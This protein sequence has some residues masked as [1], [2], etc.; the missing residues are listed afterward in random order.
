MKLPLAVIIQVERKN[1]DLIKSPS[2]AGGIWKFG[3]LKSKS[4]L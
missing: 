3:R 2:V 1:V 4:K